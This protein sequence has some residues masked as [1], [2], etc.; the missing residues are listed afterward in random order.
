MADS[1]F[2]C[3]LCWEP[4]NLFKADEDDR[5][6]MYGTSSS[7][8]FDQAQTIAELWSEYPSPCRNPESPLDQQ[9]L[10]SFQRRTINLAADAGHPQD[11]DIDLLTTVSGPESMPAELAS[12]MLSDPRTLLKLCRG[13]EKRLA[14]L[15]FSK[16]ELVRSLEMEIEEIRG[17]LTEVSEAVNRDDV[18]PP[19]NSPQ[20]EEDSFVQGFALL[21]L[22]SP[23]TDPQDFTQQYNQAWHNG[24]LIIVENL[25]DHARTRDIHALFHS[26]GT[27]TYLE[28]HGADKSKPHVNSR[29]AYI[30][31]AEYNQAVTAVQNHHGAY[32]HDRALMVFLLST[33]TVR[34]EPG[35]PYLGPALEILN[36]AGG[37]NYASPDADFRHANEELQELLEHLDTTAPQQ[38]TA[39]EPSTYSLG[40]GFTAKTSVSWRR[41]DAPLV[42][43]EALSKTDMMETVPTIVETSPQTPFTILAEIKPLAVGQPGAYIPP[44]PRKRKASSVADDVGDTDSSRSH[45][46][47]RI[48]KRGEPLPGNASAVDRRGFKFARRDVEDFVYEGR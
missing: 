39:M 18:R 38:Q 28:L 3:S 16:E 10:D 22:Q 43:T 13:L 45:P 33:D 32:F 19:C 26:C 17:L 12:E 8:T 34:G 25:S 31:F 35:V 40:P 6:W 21:E 11:P 20:S 9:D 5:D 27:I 44:K 24:G 48:L 36:F 46:A 23:S 14:D 2:C 37:M 41:T 7:G 47:M 29:Y 30:H 4:P 15:E 42:E 1:S